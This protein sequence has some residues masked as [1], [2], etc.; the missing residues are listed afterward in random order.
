MVSNLV[1]ETIKTKPVLGFDVKSAEA[2][3]VS[4]ANAGHGPSQIG[5]ILRD[6]HGVRDFNEFTGKSIQKVLEENNLLGDIPEDMLNLI[7]KSVTLQNHMTIN[8]KDYS[9]KRG[10]QLTVSKIRR[11]GKYYSKKGRLPS[12]WRYSP[13]QAALLVK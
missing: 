6:E 11:L 1:K 5:I 12:D 4:L 10:Y 2:E 13:E 9:A 8:K 7:R 3:V